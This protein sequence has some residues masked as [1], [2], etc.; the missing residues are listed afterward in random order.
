MSLCYSRDDESFDFTEL[1]DLMADLASDDALQPGTVYYEA[2]FTPMTPEYLIDACLDHFLEDCDQ[3]V[4]DEV[5]EVYDNDF[6]GTSKEAQ[7][8]L[9][10]LILS[11]AEKHIKM[12]YWRIDG[13]SRKK[14]FSKEEIEEYFA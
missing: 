8:E 3:A 6:S 13:K 12:R 2:D 1:G 11:W 9:R 4:Y 10:A 5:G 14:T 7:L